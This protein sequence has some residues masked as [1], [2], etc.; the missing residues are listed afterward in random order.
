MEK[1][2][3][4]IS[5]KMSERE[6]NNYSRARK[7]AADGMVLLENRGVLPI[8]S[9][10][11]RIALFGNGARRTVKGGTGSGDVN[12]RFFITVEQG[13]ERA[14]FEIGTKE[15]LGRFD[16][17]VNEGQTA[18]YQKIRSII[19]ERGQEGILE[20]FLNPFQEPPVPQI[21]DQDIEKSKTDTAIYVIARNSGEAKD[22]Q[23]IPGQYELFDEEIEAIRKVS[24]QYEKCIV[25][26]NVGAV[27]D[28][29]FIR[30][31]REIG[32]VLLMGQPGC[33]AGDALVDSL[34]GK[35]VP[36]GKLAA[37]WADNYTDYPEAEEF[38]N[39]DD[40]YYREGIYVGYRYFDTFHVNP[41]YPFG[42]GLSYTE[43]EIH[44]KQITVSDGNVSVEVSV[45]NTG[46]IFAGREVVQVYVS[47]PKDIMEKPYQELVAFQKTELLA[48]GEEQN[49]TLTFQ[50]SQMA[51]YHS[52]R[53]E[54]ILEKGTYY[55]RVGSHSRK[56]H[57][58]AALVLENE[59]VTEKLRN[60]MP[61]DCCMD[62]LS[63][64]GIQPWS[65]DGEDAEKQSAFRIPLTWEI[66]AVSGKSNDAFESMKNKDGES[67]ESVLSVSDIL[68]GRSTIEALISQL[69]VEELVT[70]CV[71]AVHRGDGLSLG[72]ES[73]SRPGAGGETSS[74][75]KKSRNVQ[76]LILADG[77]AGLRLRQKFCIDSQGNVVEEGGASIPE[78]N[79]VIDFPEPEIPENAVHY[80]QYCTALPTATLMAQTWDLEALETEGNIV[81][82]EMTELG[83]H[84]WL[85]PGLN[86]QRNPLC[87]RNFE[88]YSEDPLVSGLCA[89]SVIRG[90]QKYPG[91]G[92]TIKHFAC[93][94]QED[95]RTHN[96]V[97][98]EER[99]LR[100][101]YLKG[102][103]IA[104]KGAS[105]VAIMSSYNL[106]NG[107]HTANSSDLLNGIV[108]EE[109]KFDGI[110][111]SD[112]G[113]TEKSKD[114]ETTK[115]GSPSAVGCIKAGNCLIMPGTQEDI[116]DI[117]KG[118]ETDQ[119][120]MEELKRCAG[121][122]LST[123][124]KLQK[125]WGEE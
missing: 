105:P 125:E 30:S 70:I 42:Y 113:T 114:W 36:S 9:N 64:E 18:Y 117:M 43:F 68:N 121:F 81:G 7:L 67:E 72:A 14:G 33:S 50:I 78:I 32:A 61:I 48:P 75:L 89:T 124:I 5:S 57:V 108:R 107:I 56:T 103:E 44:A 102:F 26:L 80:Y 37:T 35:V 23:D 31:C 93:N 27:I 99:A 25:V 12:S 88:Y 83:I 123:V 40:V 59:I 85:A 17:K 100:E 53:A 74:I 87:G 1:I 115:Y 21:T 3:A 66:A 97:H 98:I 109:W 4:A 116:D 13:L 20:L 79:H 111:M 47:A 110:I 6:R 11:K 55:L 95:N 112:W 118:I 106:I 22:R 24:T 90:V 119:C 94:N 38:G 39:L 77:P 29:K 54:Y 101:I 65:Y 76:N 86:I 71:G 10:T 69:S 62:L 15:W 82:E 122:V 96:C 28:T 91:I 92:T 41:A 19:V 63:S 2:Y 34:T 60:R 49:V 52:V 73:N 120:S 16:Q 104:V 45:K 8:S 51:S 84:L 46:N 58:A